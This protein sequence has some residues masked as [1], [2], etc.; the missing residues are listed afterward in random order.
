MRAGAAR[1]DAKIDW[2]KPA[3]EVY[4]L[5]RG[6]NPQPG[7]WTTHAGSEVQ[8]F[9]SAASAIRIRNSW[10]GRRNQR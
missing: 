9:D 5:I 2:S 4:N 8:I 10:S 7:S 1:A 3:D 6:T